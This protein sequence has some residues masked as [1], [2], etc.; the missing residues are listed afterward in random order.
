[1]D[2][3]KLLDLGLNKNEAIIYLALLERGESQAGEISK[4][5]QINRTTVYDTVERLI[6]KGLVS[7]SISANK[8]IFK[9]VSPEIIIEQLKEKKEIAEEV[10]PS[11]KNLYRESKNKED[12]TTYKGKK[13]IKSIFEEVLEYKEYLAFGSSG[14]ILEVMKHDFVLFQ[15]RKKELKIKSKVI[16]SE[17]ARKNREFIKVSH[18]YFKYLPEEFSMP[19]TFIIYGINVAIITWGEIPIASVITSEQVSDSFKRYFELLW[20]IAKP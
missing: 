13:G 1:M 14:K 4:K 8:K 2:I 18:A 15:K 11:L 10:L 19:T 16:E 9:P 17:N 3:E 5:T 12:S 6:E 20:K 7:Y